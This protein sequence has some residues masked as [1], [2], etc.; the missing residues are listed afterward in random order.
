M[1]CTDMVNSML[2]AGYRG[3][4]PSVEV[5]PKLVSVIREEVEA[6]K[7]SQ[8]LT[9]L[10]LRGVGK[11]LQLL[12]ER[13]EYQ[14]SLRCLPLPASACCRPCSPALLPLRSWF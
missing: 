11:A 12:A 13:A 5:V 3:S 10:V 4:I 7:S 2:P 14:V 1:R 9:V 8:A 6:V